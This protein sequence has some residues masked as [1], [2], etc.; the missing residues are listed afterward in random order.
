MTSKNE[1]RVTVLCEDKSHFDFVRGYLKTLGFNHRKIFSEVAPLGRGSGEQYVR[2]KFSKT[3]TSFRKHQRG[4]T[5]LVVVTD[6]DKCT[7]QKRLDSLTNTLQTP[8]QAKE[9]IIILIPKRNI[10]TWFRYAD[11]P[12]D[13]NEAKD[14]KPKYKK[15]KPSKY[16]KKYAE[17]ICPNPLSNALS[18]L[19][20]ACEEIKRLKGLL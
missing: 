11:D 17:N 16:G 20:E 9:R 6:A 7:Y 4:N 15:V 2:K 10:E 13:C 1:Y 14:Y 5:I 18:A 8:L 3:A 19:K 12:T